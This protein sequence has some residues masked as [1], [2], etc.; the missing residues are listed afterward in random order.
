MHAPS[1]A[2]TS[3][4]NRLELKRPTAVALSNNRDKKSIELVAAPCSDDDTHSSNQSTSVDPSST[5]SQDTYFID[6]K[7]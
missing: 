6:F 4:D 7:P 3:N 2:S 1:L 5:P